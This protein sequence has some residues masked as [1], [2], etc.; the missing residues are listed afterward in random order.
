MFRTNRSIFILIT[1]FIM[2]FLSF[3]SCDEEESVYE[4]GED[5]AESY[6]Q[7]PGRDIDTTIYL[8]MPS[9]TG[10]GD[11]DEKGTWKITYVFIQDPGGSGEPTTDDE[12]GDPKSSNDTVIVTIQDPGGSGEPTT[13]DN[14][15][16]SGDSEGGKDATDK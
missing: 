14:S 8:R 10:D 11:S 2:I 3:T 1:I 5:I 13:D 4:N 7:D 12:S 16:D 9:G 6:I 15:G